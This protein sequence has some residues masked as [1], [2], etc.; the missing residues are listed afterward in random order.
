MRYAFSSVFVVQIQIFRFLMRVR[1][2]FV[3]L[4]ARSHGI[5]CLSLV[6]F[7]EISEYF[8]DNLSRKLKVNTYV[9][10]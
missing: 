10:V 5:T 4:S 2:I 6:D 7:H 8:F 1:K 9:R 3:S